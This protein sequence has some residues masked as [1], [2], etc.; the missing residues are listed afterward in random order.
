[1]GVELINQG[2]V[3]KTYAELFKDICR[4]VKNHFK[5]F[6]PAKV[7]SCKDYG[8]YFPALFKEPEKYIV[9]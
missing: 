5:H 9:P 6:S 3:K 8:T 7:G 2:K 4:T 1:M